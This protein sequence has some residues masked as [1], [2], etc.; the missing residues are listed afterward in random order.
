[1]NRENYLLI[2]IPLS[3]LE[4]E[5]FEAQDKQDRHPLWLGAG[6]LLLGHAVERAEAKDQVAAG[7]ADY[8]A[9]GK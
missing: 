6:G 8:F 4:R 9:T 2:V 5:H 3:G 7:Y 1:L